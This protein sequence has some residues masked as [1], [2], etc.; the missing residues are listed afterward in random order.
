ML[1]GGLIPPFAID[2]S[3]VLSM[4]F[5]GTG[6]CL[7]MFIRVCSKSHEEKGYSQFIFVKSRR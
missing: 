7:V 2:L 4:S 1:A 6:L 3:V 5:C